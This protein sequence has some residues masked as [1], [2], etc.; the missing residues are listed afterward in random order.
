MEKSFYSIAKYFLFLAI[1][2]LLLWF[3]FRNQNFSQLWQSLKTANYYWVFLSVCISL[4]AHWIRALR[5]KM[6]MQP[7]GFQPKTSNTFHAVMIGYLANLAFPRLGEVTRCAVLN[8]SDNI[9]LNSLIGTVL[10][11]RV[12]DVLF[13]FLLLI[14][15]VVLLY[16]KIHQFIFSQLINPIL[17]K[18]DNGFFVTI[19]ITAAFI[20]FF[21]LYIFIKNNIEKL[22][23]IS[24]L[25]KLFVFV[26]GL[27]DG[28]LSVL[29]LQKRTQFFIYSIGIWLCYFLSTYICFFALKETAHLSLLIGLFVMVAGGI[30]MSA[31]I[32]GGI[33]AFEAT[34]SLSLL[35][36]AIPE[37]TGLAYATISHSSQILSI[38]VVGSISLLLVFLSNRKQ[39]N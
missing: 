28:F 24:V 23:K 18:F 14:L 34:V 6:L 13:L 8:K 39:K 30:G 32:Q 11:E 36:F 4:V 20:I 9:P 10:L 5:W 38:I 17:E 1:A 3:S 31:P 2:V 19:I 12:V 35:L 21:S 15:S 16:E 22:K 33:G 29:K 37:S 7:I 27:K 25:N 26:E